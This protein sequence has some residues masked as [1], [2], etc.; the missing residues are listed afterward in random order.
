MGQNDL[1]VLAEA[2]EASAEADLETQ[3]AIRAA[4]SA[5]MPGL[6]S[7]ESVF[8]HTDDVLHLI[9]QVLP[10]WTISL[11]G[12]AHEPNGHWTCTLRESSWRDSDALLGIGRGP[13][14]HQAL[15]AALLRVMALQ[16]PG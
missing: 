5:V 15:L 8:G 12:K 11:T 10:D 13:Q 4:I 14:P 2:I 16:A 9:D 7:T 3:A 1:K 6:K